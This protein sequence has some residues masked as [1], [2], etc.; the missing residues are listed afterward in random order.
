MKIIVGLGNPGKKYQLSRHNAGFLM[1]DYLFDELKET[2]NFSAWQNSK[3][4]HAEISEGNKD[5]NKILLVKPQTFMNASGLAVGDLFHF[6]KIAPLD[7]I[8]IHDDLDLPFGTFK[9]QNNISS[10]GHKG[11]KSIIEKIGTQ[12]FW[13]LRVGLAKKKMP[14]SSETADFVLGNFNL[15]QRIKLNSLKKQLKDELEKILA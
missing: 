4:F 9:V 13:R 5:G 10:A 12:D 14:D 7:L 2:Y 6:Y 11:I 15:L 8:V 1:L 3:K